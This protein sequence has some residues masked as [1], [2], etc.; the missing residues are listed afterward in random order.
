MP[1]AK[2][3]PSGCGIH[4]DRT[5]LRLDFYLNPDDPNYD[6]AHA[7]VVDETSKEFQ[8]GY[9][10]KLDTEGSPIAPVDYQ[11]WFGGL[12]HI[13]RDNPFHCHFIYPDKDATD[14]DIK[15]E[16]GMCLDYFH[17]FHQQMWD[18][19]KKFIDEWKKVPK[20]R[21]SIRDVFVKGD[22]KDL[23]KHQVKVQDI[24]NRINEFQI[25]DS[26]APPQGLN[27]GEKGTIDVGALATLRSAVA[28]LNYTQLDNTNPANASGTI[29]TVQIYAE[30]PMVDVSEGLFYLDS[31][32]TY[33][34]RDS[35]RTIGNVIGSPAE[36]TGLSIDVVT[37]DL[38]GV[39]WVSGSFLERDN[40]GG[41]SFHSLGEHIDP[42]DSSSYTANTR[43]YSLYGTGTE[44]GVGWTH[45]FLGVANASIGKINGVAIADILKVN[46]VE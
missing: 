23:S 1:Y 2:I 18:A 41:T 43:I 10:G 8:G 6:K 28:P 4:K 14:A 33:V 7:F 37:D 27:I 26:K 40:T 9:K 20:V 29:D 42:S 46:G 13:W 45:K 39:Y 3:E 21:G 12:P 31:G 30:A 16:I 35:D 17:T 25:G 22:P 32:T 15:A 36:F 5:K 11:L 24:T 34:C 19:D 44:G 38:I